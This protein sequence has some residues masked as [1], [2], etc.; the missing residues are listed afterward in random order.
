MHVQFSQS[1]SH[2]EKM[3]CLISPDPHPIINKSVF[4]RRVNKTADEI[5]SKINGVEFNMG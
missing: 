3:S 2:H 5:K 4:Q 1:V